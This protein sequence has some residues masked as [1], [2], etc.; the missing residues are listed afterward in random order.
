MRR[1]LQS[2]VVLFFVSMATFTLMHAVPGDPLAA[3]IGERQADRPEVR[4]ALERRYGLDKPLPVQYVYYVKAVVLHGDLGTTIT[5]RRPVATEL[6]KFVPATIELSMAAMLFAIGVGVP[7]GIIAAI[8]QNR[9]QD[10][11]A[12]FLSLVGTAMPVFWLGLLA[13]YVISFKLRWLPRAG[14]KDTGMSIPERVTGFMSVDA[15]IAGDWAFLESYLRHM[16][17]PAVVLGAYAMGIISRMLRSSLLT[18]LQDDYVRTAR[19]KGLGEFRVVSGHALRNALIPTIT[20]IGL[21]FASLLAGAVLTETIFSWPG[22]GQF[23]VNM[24]LKLDYPGLLGATLFVAVA[25][26]LV[27]L[28]VDITYGFLDPR[29]RSS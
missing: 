19:A 12:R 27:N 21:T 8:R 7:L 24:A 13:S 18:A 10:N 5:T 9:W 2:L 3:V 4:Q 22:V 14:F 17:L 28:A 25:Y 11:L 15:V 1:L 29:I 26:I 20:V 16:I 6:G 23:A